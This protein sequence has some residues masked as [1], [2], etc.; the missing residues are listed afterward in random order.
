[1]SLHVLLGSKRWISSDGR[2]R[3]GVTGVNRCRVTDE[4]KDGSVKGSFRMPFNLTDKE[5]KGT[6]NESK[7]LNYCIECN[8]NTN[9]KRR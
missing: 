3:N 6:N 2:G 8:R 4:R 7:I 1:M 5:S 9:C